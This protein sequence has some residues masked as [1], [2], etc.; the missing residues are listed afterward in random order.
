MMLYLGSE[1]GYKKM[2]LGGFR[3]G[4]SIG[5]I[6]IEGGE[7]KAVSPELEA[8]IADWIADGTLNKE[9]FDFLQTVWDIFERHYEPSKKAIRYV[10]G[11]NIGKIQPRSIETPWGTYKGGYA[12]IRFEGDYGGTTDLTTLVLENDNYVNDFFPSQDVGW[13]K[14]RSEKLKPLSLDLG[15]LPYNLNRVYKAAYMMPTMF[16]VGKVFNGAEF[17]E[18]LESRRPGAMSGIVIPWFKRVTA[19]RYT[20]PADGPTSEFFD[21]IARPITRN[22]RMV[23]YMFNLATAFKQELGQIQAI[24]LVGARRILRANAQTNPFRLNALAKEI[25]DRN[26]RMKVRLRG[27]QTRMVQ[28]L[29]GIDLDM[30]DSSLGRIQDV[31]EKVT[32]WGIHY[33]QTHVDL[34]IYQAATEMA[35]NELGLTDQQDID[36]YAMDAVERTQMSSDIASRPDALLGSETKKL[37]TTLS[38]V[39]IAMFGRN[40]EAYMRAGLAD[41]NVNRERVKAVS[42]MLMFTAFTPAIVGFMIGNP[43]RTVRAISDEDEREEYFEDMAAQVVGETRDVVAPLAGRGLW[44]L[45]S[46]NLGDIAPAVSVTSRAMTSSGRGAKA[47]MSEDDEITVREI[48]AMP[49]PLPA[50]SISRI[51]KVARQIDPEIE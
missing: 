9:D 13:T 1:S 12:P 38:S 7:G 8:Q 32:F 19:Q 48:E 2:V 40:Y 47:L 14:Q 43:I 46:G 22:S 10:Y 23:L 5:T 3:V 50:S 34:V 6:D 30:S 36:S 45:A 33:L 41:T 20:D 24:P 16:D 42:M 27:N 51:L 21:R 28:A 17:K 31:A 11:R 35:V 4:Q 18:A 25:S 29:E 26:P 39:P 37:F 49:S 15:K 44:A